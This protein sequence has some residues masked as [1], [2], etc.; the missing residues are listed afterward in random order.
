[1]PLDFTVGI[2]VFNEE[3]ILV[4]NIRRLCAYLDGLGSYELL[5]GVNGS[6]D[7]SAELA[8]QLADENPRIRVFETSER[9]VGSVFQMFLREAASE[10]LI[11]L[12]MDLST[13]L[14]FVSRSLRLLRTSEMVIGSKKLGC[15]N[16]SAL[17]RIGSSLYIRSASALLG[18]GVEDYSMGAKA[19][20]VGFFRALGAELGETTTYVVNCVYFA[21]RA[22]ARIVEI[23]V[24][25]QDT[26]PSKFNLGLEA[27]RKYT[28]LFGLWRR[29]T[30]LAEPAATAALASVVETAPVME[31]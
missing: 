17:R 26:R 15:Q 31:R 19:Y 22:G 9:R 24:A 20:R 3:P 2:P 25:C 30:P 5:I 14:D 23:P 21:R 16:R 6:T 8:R 12:D 4:D 13:D 7:R 18:L 27:W 11:S 29:H 28:H 10:F 1:M